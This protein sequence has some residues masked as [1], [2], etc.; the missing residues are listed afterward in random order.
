LEKS[1]VDQKAYKQVVEKLDEVMSIA[2][3]MGK[4]EAEAQAWLL[5]FVKMHY[6]PVSRALIPGAAH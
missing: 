3:G 5:D 2:T 6:L 1:K 4:T